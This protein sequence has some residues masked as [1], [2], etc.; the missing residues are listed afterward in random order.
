MGVRRPPWARV[1]APALFRLVEPQGVRRPP[2]ARVRAPA[3]FRLV[4]P[5]GAFCGLAISRA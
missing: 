4:E 3:L 5:M 1:R 2:W